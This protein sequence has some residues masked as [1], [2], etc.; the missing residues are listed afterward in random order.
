MNWLLVW[1]VVGQEPRYFAD[2]TVSRDWTISK[3]RA[4]WFNNREQAERSRNYY[5]ECG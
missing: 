3:D 4:C 5:E 2:Y 1:R